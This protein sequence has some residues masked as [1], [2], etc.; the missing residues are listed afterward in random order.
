[1][2]AKLRPETDIPGGTTLY[3][4]MLTS[5]PCPPGLY[6]TGQDILSCGFTGALFAGV[7]SAQVLFSFVKIVSFQILIQAVMGRNVMGDLI[8][9]HNKLEKDSVGITEVRK[10]A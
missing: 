4:F 10:N 3:T 8:K 9:L 5:K 7:I 1:M 6:L 2:V